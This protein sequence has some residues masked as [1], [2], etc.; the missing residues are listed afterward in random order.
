MRILKL[1]PAH[2]SW[3]PRVVQKQG[4][5]LA[6]AG[7]Q[8]SV[9]A[10]DDRASEAVEGVELL[11][12][13]NKQRTRW[14]RLGMMFRV[15]GMARR[16]PADVYH[17]HEIEA[18]PFGVL[19]KWLKRK[20]LIWDSHE[21]YH[22][23]AAENYSGWKSKL[24]T[25]LVRRM[26]KLLAR[27]ADHVIVVSFTS[28]E[29]YRDY[30]GCKNVT[31]IHNSPILDLFPCTDKPPEAKI[32]VT[33]NSYLNKERGMEQILKALALVKEKMPVRFLMVGMIPE[34]DRPLFDSLVR[35]LDIS[36]VIEVTG[37]LPYGDVGPALNRGSIG[38]MALQ[39][40]LN[41]YAT[42]HNKLYN[43]MATSQA[44]IGPGKSDT[45]KMIRKTQC[46]VVADMIRPKP[47]ADAIM[48]LL[49]DPERCRQLG[50]NGRKAVEEQFG[51][52]VMERRLRKIYED[53][54]G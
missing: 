43:Y 45:E 52:H 31:L 2:P 18:L 9:I 40:L 42:L 50:L 46:G 27:R 32:T 16:H 8:V 21:C 47:L 7:H 15:F 34:R 20:K 17:V 3:D 6:R 48:E 54:S 11:G 14:Q 13:P 36:D 38:L 49:A 30:C 37:F 28:E 24:T 44:V 26:L 4:R 51:W 29:F 33:H 19:L 39:P 12:L 23:T 53:F 22:F 25:T 1:A 41:N 5:S 35:D 10:L